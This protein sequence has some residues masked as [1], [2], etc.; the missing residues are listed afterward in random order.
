MRTDEAYIFLGYDSREDA[1]PRCTPHTAF[2]DP[3]APADAPARQSI[4]FRMLAFWENSKP[5][6][7]GSSA[8]PAFWRG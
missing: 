1:Q 3:S 6:S 5:T 4:E 7:D 8:A 2:K